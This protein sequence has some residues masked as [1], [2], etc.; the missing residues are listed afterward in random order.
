[1][2][3]RFKTILAKARN[4]CYYYSIDTRPRATYMHTIRSFRNEMK[5]VLRDLDSN[6]EEYNYLLSMIKECPKSIKEEECQS[7]ILEKLRPRF[8]ES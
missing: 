5:E 2:M 6:T 8:Y 7:Y 4:I 3:N 1:M